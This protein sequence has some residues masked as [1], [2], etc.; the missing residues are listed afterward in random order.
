M[1]KALRR[2]WTSAV[3]LLFDGLLGTVWL[4]TIA[5]LVATG[6]G[7]VAVVGVGVLM[8]VGTAWLA[9]G[10]GV[11]ERARAEAV[12]GLDIRPPQRRVTKVT[13]GW[14]IIV[15]GLL[16]FIDPVFWRQMLH[17]VLTAALGTGFL[18]LLGLVPELVGQAVRSPQVTTVVFAVIVPIALV[19]Y[20]VGAGALDR[21]LA[22][23]LLGTS[24]EVELE[25]R[26]ETLSDARQ[27]AVDAADTERRRI[28]RDLHDGVQ[29]RL[30][31]LAMTLGRAKAKFETDPVGARALLD[32]AHADAKESIIELRQLAR[33]IHPAVLTDR[34]LD[35]AL[36]AVASRCPVPT[37]VHVALPE[38]PAPEVES[39][40]YFVVAEALTNVAK[41]SDA[42]RCT[43]TVDRVEAG[44][45]AT[46][47][48]DGRGGA[49]ID[50]APS[51]GLAGLRDRARA[52]GGSL[53]V[54][55]PVDGPTVLTLEV[56]C[57]L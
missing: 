10:I 34:G 16:D 9:R 5:T 44:L 35:A 36:S 46:V 30:V 55:S 23:T 32:E 17:H 27:G 19:A 24:R 12:H 47:D 22:P 52:A 18:V 57:A 7:L 31:A 38:R 8:L 13:N 43:V 11:V 14:R 25:H 20:V 39:V 6:L 53:T 50:N 33:G 4:A 48:D 54:D 49:S 2:L 51:G 15:Q 28:E 3:D 21:M 37:T 1:T 56:P 45:R 29:P 26:V 42:T 41:H 40:V